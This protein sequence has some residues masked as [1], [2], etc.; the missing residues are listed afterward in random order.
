MNLLMPKLKMSKVMTLKDIKVLIN[1]IPEEFDYYQ[2]T[3]SLS[4]Y[5]V[6][7]T[8]VNLSPTIYMENAVINLYFTR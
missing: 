2:L 7:S 3:T 6:E 4:D 5:D 1:S 8:V